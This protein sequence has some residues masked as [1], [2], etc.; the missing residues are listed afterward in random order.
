MRNDH[1][2]AHVKLKEEELEK[3]NNMDEAILTRA[4]AKELNKNPNFSL[5][6]L[7]IDPPPEIAA[8]INEELCSDDAEDEEYRPGEDEI[9]VI[10]ISIVNNI[11]VI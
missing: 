1:I 11:I 10:W 8:L 4:K 2:L 9:P 7:K 5:A 6:P 3:E